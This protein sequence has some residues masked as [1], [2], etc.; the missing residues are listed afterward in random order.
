MLKRFLVNWVN[1]V[2]V[3]GGFLVFLGVLVGLP[4]LA[5][6]FFDIAGAAV[7]AFISTTLFSAA[8]VT[9]G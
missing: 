9:L 8:V 4:I 5:Y 6:Q 7:G 2:L 3:V 1:S